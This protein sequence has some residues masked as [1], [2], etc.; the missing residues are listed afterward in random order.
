MVIFDN[1]TDVASFG[2]VTRI[3]DV[4]NEHISMS[5]AGMTIM[6]GSTEVAVF[7]ANV[8]MS[9]G[10]VLIG[11]IGGGEPNVSITSGG[12]SLRHGTTDILTIEDDGNIQVSGSILEKTRLFGA[13]QD[14]SAVL[15]HDNNDRSGPVDKAS[16]TAIN[17]SR[18]EAIMANS[19]ATW[20]MAKDCYFDD[21]TISATGG[22]TYLKTNGFRLY[23]KGTLALASNT[24]IDNPG[25]RGSNG[26]NAVVVVV[27]MWIS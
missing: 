26:G 25:I 20:S 16:N 14:G 3:G 1:N 19:S 2:A 18:G 13:G 23:V 6:D 21:L 24:I 12:V 4:A 11:T 27:V 22:N 10:G 7:G 15:Y 8:T 9:R 5:D 17:N